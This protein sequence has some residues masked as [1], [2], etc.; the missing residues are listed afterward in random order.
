MCKLYLNERN[1]YW[2]SHRIV[3]RAR[4]PSSGLSFWEQCVSLGQRTSLQLPVPST[5]AKNPTFQFTAAV[6]CRTLRPFPNPNVSL[7]P[8]LAKWLAF[9][10][11][12]SSHDSLVNWFHTGEPVLQLGKESSGFYRR[13]NMKNMSIPGPGQAE[14]LRC[15]S[16]Q[17]QH[18]C[19]LMLPSLIWTR[20]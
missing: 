10:R 16:P 4:E 15:K 17:T 14:L 8:L 3:E 18:I 20:P 11:L 7:P 9:V 5:A 6:F 1:E 13:Q 2:K 19:L 12:S